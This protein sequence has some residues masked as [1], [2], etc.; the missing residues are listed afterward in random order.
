[1]DS[2]EDIQ[3]YLSKNLFLASTLYLP[4]HVL[5]ALFDGKE[6]DNILY[7]YVN[8]VFIVESNGYNYFIEDDIPI[9][10]NSLSKKTILDKNLIRL[11]ELE[12]ERTIKVFQFIANDY[13]EKINGLYEISNYY[14]SNVDND[15]KYSGKHIKR[16]FEI[17][18]E[19]IKKHITD[20]K[21]KLSFN[22]VFSN[23]NPMSLLDNG[24]DFL[25]KMTSEEKNKELLQKQY[26]L[27]LN[28]RDKKSITRK[29]KR[30]TLL[31][32]EDLILESIFNVDFSMI[33][34]KK[35]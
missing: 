27:M 4:S 31:L 15:I 9:G 16:A 23:S 6:E 24:M 7:D 33:N 35:Q 10:I 30:N 29:L 18:H 13:M 8:K 34:T 20:L 2:Y 14:I 28:K 1:M 11:F 12:T 3:N 19:S 32:S 17:Q 21:G 5:D 25:N 26:N 22:T